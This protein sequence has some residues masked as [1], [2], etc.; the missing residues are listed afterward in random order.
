MKNVPNTAGKVKSDSKGNVFDFNTNP[1]LY[2]G[3]LRPDGS[4]RWN[5]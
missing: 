5:R 2:A 1:P 4:V 3:K